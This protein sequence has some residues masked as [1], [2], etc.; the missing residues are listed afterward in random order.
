MATTK[1]FKVLQ[2]PDFVKD[3]KR[4]SKKFRTLE[5]D[6]KTFVETALFLYHKQGIDNNGIFHIPGLQF[7][8]PRVYKAKKF[9]CKSLKGSGVHS[10]IRV[11]YAYDSISDTVLLIELYYKGEK[12]NEDKSR[13]AENIMSRKRAKK[14]AMLGEDM[15]V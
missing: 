1:F 13:L 12:E 8:T 7:S 14:T 5:S 6:L 4:L 11:I 3:L 15:A 9:A 2:L 10:G